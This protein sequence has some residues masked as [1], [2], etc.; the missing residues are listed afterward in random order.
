MEDQWRL[1]RGVS[2]T[3]GVRMD[4]DH[5]AGSNASPRAA[6]NLTPITGHAVLLSYSRGYRLPAPIETYLQEFYFCSDPDLRAERID[7]LEAGWRWS[8]PTDG[9]EAGLNLFGSRADRLIWREP[10]AADRMQANWIAWLN[11]GSPDLTRQPGPFFAYSNLDNPAFVGGA[12]ASGRAR[13]PGTPCTLWGNATWQRLR[14]RDPVRLQSDG[15]IDPLTATRVFAFDADLGRDIDAPPPWKGVAGCDVAHE[16]WHGG[17]ALRA[18]AG[19]RVFSIANSD[20]HDG[21]IRTQRI[22]G[23]ACLDLSVGRTWTG[24]GAEAW[25]RLA[26][27]DLLDSDH[28]E[29]W[30]T[31]T[32][33]LRTYHEDQNGSRIGRQAALQ[34][35]IGF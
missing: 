17:L 31:D 16:G 9:L 6:I 14:Y 34:G 32:A 26:V 8:S 28:A 4:G 23:Y 33:Y 5:Q 15:F 20:P 29:T 27:L 11:G 18:V 22:P 25:L 30:Q 1:L 12:E 3:G 35:G 2:L 24:A 10:L 7:A 21:I 19:R 13:L